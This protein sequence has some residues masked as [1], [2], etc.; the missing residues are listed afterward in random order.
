MGHAGETPMNKLILTGILL[1]TGLGCQG[2]TLIG[3][4]DGGR[5]HVTFPAS[6]F[7]GANILYP[8][9]D[10]FQS[11]WGFSTVRYE[12]VV[13]HD[14]TEMV[15]VNMRLLSD[16]SGPGNWSAGGSANDWRDTTSLDAGTW[17]ESFSTPMVTGVAEE[18][19][20]FTFSGRAQ[21]DVYTCGS[22][23]PA[24][25][26]TISWSAPDGGWTATDGGGTATDGGGRPT[27]GGG[28]ATDGGARD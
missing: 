22:T 1:L 14:A 23:T 28:T 27:D 9:N 19:I 2:N 15:T 4:A 12:L 20:Y 18:T 7:F 3:G 26:K 6:G 10:T 13:Q 17:V 25:T 5:C 24:L 8:G 11:S 16:L 21:V